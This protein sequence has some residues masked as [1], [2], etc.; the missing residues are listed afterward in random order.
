MVITPLL[1]TSL[2]LYLTLFWS[3]FI[4]IFKVDVAEIMVGSED[5]DVLPRIAGPPKDFVK[6]SINSRP[7]RPGGLEDSQSA[8]RILPDGASNGDWVWEVLNGGPA[9]ALPPSFKQGMD[10]GNLKV[11]YLICLLKD[12]HTATFLYSINYN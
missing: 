2:F 8:G 6:G 1:S 9:Q 12:P 7:F 4:V 3:W 5:S 10:F 11:T